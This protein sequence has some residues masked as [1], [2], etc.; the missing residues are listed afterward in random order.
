MLDIPN[1][2]W[3]AILEFIPDR[4]LCHLMGVNHV[5]YEL[6][7][8]TRY[9]EIT[10]G[11]IDSHSVSLLKRLQDPSIACRV[12]KL[13]IIPSA[14]AEG[15]TGSR[16]PTI[17]SRIFETLQAFRFAIYASIQISLNSRNIFFNTAAAPVDLTPPVVTDLINSIFPGLTRLERLSVDFWHPPTVYDM[18]SVLSTAWP[19]IGSH[20]KTLFLGGN[21]ATFRHMIATHPVLPTLQELIFQLTDPFLDTRAENT[22]VLNNTIAPFVNSFAA[23][24]QG[25]TFWSWASL[26][27]SS[28][29]TNLGSFPMMK[30][31]HVRLAFNKALAS[32]PAGLAQF[33]QRHQNTLE[34]L[35]LWLNPSGA[36][37]DH[38]LDLPLSQWLSHTVTAIQQFPRMKELQFYPTRLEAGLMPSYSLSCCR[39][40]L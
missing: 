2:I 9:R 16:T 28:L 27:I 19:A 29:F 8:D 37:A 22:D 15:D 10:I 7:L 4:E 13:N 36:A 23:T 20:L 33:V 14:T 17:G 31:I 24:L 38:S 35:Q 3:L 30:R 1:E 11:P 6:G 25:F 18:H 5:F 34:E 40:K 39:W 12:R 32:D 26:D 21:L